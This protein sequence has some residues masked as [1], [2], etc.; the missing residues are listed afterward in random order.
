MEFIF[1]IFSRAQV[2]LGLNQEIPIL[3]RNP[4]AFFNFLFGAFFWKIQAFYRNIDH[5]QLNVCA[6]FCLDRGPMH[7]VVCSCS[8]TKKFW[9]RLSMLQVSNQSSQL[10]HQA[11]FLAIGKNSGQKNS[12]L[13]GEN[14][15]LKLKT[16]IF[17][18][19]WKF[20]IFF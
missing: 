2:S 6:D 5:T 12:K 19:F 10:L 17:G 1:Q 14:H 3:G 7:C 13:K 8:V 15:K 16:Q 4:P 18:T 20:C 11:Y 9:A